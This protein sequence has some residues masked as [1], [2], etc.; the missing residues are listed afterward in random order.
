MKAWIVGRNA[1]TW[2]HPRCFC[3]QITCDYDASGRSK[4]KLTG[5][6]FEKGE[7]KMGTRS[8]TATNW[9]KRRAF[10]DVLRLVSGALEGTVV[11]ADDID[12][13]DE[14][15]ETQQKSIAAALADISKKQD[16]KPQNQTKT[17]GKNHKG[18]TDTTTSDRQPPTGTVSRASGRVEWRWASMVCS[19]T[20]LPSRETKSHCY[21]RT[22]KGNVKTLAKGKS[23]W[24]MCKTK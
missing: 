1:M 17:N 13:Y 18:T 20:L 10:G 4:C 5:Q 22:H 2:Q 12:G 19:G 16:K 24:W 11:R 7:L 15:D 9:Y 21:A 23:Y 14:M 8:H 3:M 6:K